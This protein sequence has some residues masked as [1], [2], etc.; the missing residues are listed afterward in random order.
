MNVPP[1]LEVSVKTFDDARKC[2][3]KHKCD[4]R[5]IDDIKAEYAQKF[6]NVNYDIK[7]VEKLTKERDAII[8]DRQ[9]FKIFCECAIK[10][11]SS[12]IEKFRAATMSWLE[13]NAKQLKKE[14]NAYQKERIR[15]NNQHIRDLK[16]AKTLNDILKKLVV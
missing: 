7:K 12:D 16:Q 15:I 1:K 3:R 14:K 13:F 5:F 8:L 4:S 11:C 6:R 9:E 2:I 10:S